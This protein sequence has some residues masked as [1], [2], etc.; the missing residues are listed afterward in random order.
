[1]AA[2]TRKARACRTSPHDPMRNE[3]TDAF[4]LISRTCLALV[5]FSAAVQCLC[6]THATSADT[7]GACVEATKCCCTPDSEVDQ[8]PPALS[9]SMPTGLTVAPDLD[10]APLVVANSC[11]TPGSSHSAPALQIQPMMSGPP[12]PLY[13]SN[14]SFLL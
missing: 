11:R 9:P 10:S 8:A 3:L 7:C 5:F 6:I 14:A 4:R 12:G 13:V 2:I 1:M